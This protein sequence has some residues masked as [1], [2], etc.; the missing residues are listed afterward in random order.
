M[1]QPGELRG[2]MTDQLICLKDVGNAFGIGER[3][4]SAR[5]K[6]EGWVRVGGGRPYQY[7][8]DDLPPEVQVAFLRAQSV[9][10]HESQLE[11][12]D[13]DFESLTDEEK[14]EARRWIRI[15]IE[16]EGYAAA[17]KD[18]A[19]TKARVDFCRLYEIRHPNEESFSAGTL[20]RK[21][22]LLLKE[23][24][25][26]LASR[27]GRTKVYARWSDEA[28]A[29]LKQLYLTDNAPSIAWCVR[30]TRLEG[31]KH[32]WE[33][34]SDDTMRRHLVSVPEE[35]RDYFRRG[36]V[37][38]RQKHW[39]CVL[40]DYNSMRPGE[41]FVADHRILDLVCWLRNGKKG[42]PWV[43]AVLDMRTRLLVGWY[44]D[45]VPSTAT[46]LMALHHAFRDYGVPANVM[47]DNGRDFSSRLLSGGCSRFRLKVDAEEISGVLLQ[48]L[49]KVLFTLPAWPR[50]KII[51]R[52]F[53]GMRDFERSFPTYLGS[54]TL[55]RPADVDGRLR[56]GR[57]IP[58]LA[59]VSKAFANFVADWNQNH[60]HR[61]HG[62][63]GRTPM[64][65]WSEYFKNHAISRP[66]ARSLEFLLLRGGIGKISRNG[67][68][69]LN[70]FYWSEELAGRVGES[71]QYRYDP[72]N[73]DQIF[74]SKGDGS[75][76][77]QA[78][79]RVRTG[80]ND[81]EAFVKIRR[82]EKQ[83][84]RGAKLEVEA[85]REIFKL[86]MGYR[87]APVKDE[88][89]K[90]KIVQL[91][92]TLVDGS[93]PNIV[94]EDSDSGPISA[95]GEAL[96]RRYRRIASQGAGPVRLSLVDKENGEED[97]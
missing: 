42:R 95:V 87:E 43:T 16:F 80:W 49:I 91:H 61:G 81:E 13:D 72:D 14:E 65:A 48:L 28:K 59:A 69:A 93:I 55:E 45:A 94:R 68:T 21:G 7:R 57:D 63:R 8:I 9:S 58:D 86:E 76:L 34:P 90:E 97:R 19:R 96:A 17:C 15:I 82:F 47:F 2:R 32:G 30:Q 10:A 62:M 89:G 92:R 67:I 38:C 23:G 1:A 71:I 60:R 5:A 6:R 75:F 22:K 88:I 11:R 25:A 54:N 85:A 24:R 66:S 50:S 27:Y 20:K 56:R 4:A 77:C 40:R 29:F 52:W 12:V 26:A 73:L 70:S 41:I 31:Q 35:T 39:P 84:R 36:E 83:R 18:Q 46:I 74:V 44:M 64:E 79:R 3:A 51:E 78:E 37:F 53:L 33:L